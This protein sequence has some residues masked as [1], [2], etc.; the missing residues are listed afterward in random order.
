LPFARLSAY[1]YSM[2]PVVERIARDTLRHPPPRE[3]NSRLSASQI[4]TAIWCWS[5]FWPNAR[6]ARA[7]QCSESTIRNLKNRILDEPG[8]LFNEIG[9]DFLV[10]EKG[11]RRYECGLCRVAR[12]TRTAGQRHMLSHILP[13]VVAREC[14]LERDTDNLGRVL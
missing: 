2:V 6:I 7:S 4:Y 14:S 3:R 12:G 11:K 13:G 9:L 10:M 5:D 8:I 1:N